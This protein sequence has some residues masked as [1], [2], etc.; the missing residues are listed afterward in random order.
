MSIDLVRVGGNWK[1]TDLVLATNRLDY[2]TDRTQSLIMR[3]RRASNKSLYQDDLQEAVMQRDLFRNKVA[4]LKAYF[5]SPIGQSVAQASYANLP[6]SA[7]GDLSLPKLVE[8]SSTNLP[9][10]IPSAIPNV[11]GGLTGL[12]SNP[13]TL[14]VLLFVIIGVMRR[15]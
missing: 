4:E 11:L 12:F 3:I 6:R 2:W 7:Y 13:I 14:L 5:S 9:S 8:N 10:G 1:P 15:K